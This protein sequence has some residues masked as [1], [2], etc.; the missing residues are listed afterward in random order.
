MCAAITLD[1]PDFHTEYDEAK[2]VWTTSWKWSGNQPPISL[3][4]RL[5]EYPTPKWLQGEYEQDLRAWIKNGWLILYLESKLGPPK[6]L[7]PLMGTIL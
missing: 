6:G 7:I 1:E 4:N 3:K 2:Y 5:S